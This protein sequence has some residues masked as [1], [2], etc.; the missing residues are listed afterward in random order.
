MI[1]HIENKSL[2]IEFSDLIIN[3]GSK[4]VI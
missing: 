4:V 1:N 3:K 2:M